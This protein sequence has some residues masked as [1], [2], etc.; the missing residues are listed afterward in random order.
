MHPYLQYQAMLPVQQTMSNPTDSQMMNEITE[1]SARLAAHEAMYNA[2]QAANDAQLKHF[3]QHEI[4]I[5]D[6][7]CKQKPNKP[8][9]ETGNAAIRVRYSCIL[10]CRTH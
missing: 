1:L 4:V 2:Q 6:L 5:Q 7:Q 10:M 3:E 9:K 8:N